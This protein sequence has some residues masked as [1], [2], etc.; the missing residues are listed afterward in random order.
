[1][2]QVPVG[3]HAADRLAT[4]AGTPF[5]RTRRRPPSPGCCTTLTQIF[6]VRACLPPRMSWPLPM[7]FCHLQGAQMVVGAPCKALSSCHAS[8]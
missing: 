4:V 1:M 7:M 8:A 2:Q 5:T 3:G 6:T